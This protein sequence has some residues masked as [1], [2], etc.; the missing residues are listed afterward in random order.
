M[1]SIQMG[2]GLA[3][4]LFSLVGAAGTT[5]LRLFF[6]TTILWI[7]WRPWRFRFDK[8]TIKSLI[9]YGGSLG[10]MNLTFYF[11]LQRIPLGLAVTLEFVGPL[12]LSILTSRKKLDFLWV[13]LAAMGIYLVM[14]HSESGSALDIL[15]IIFALIAGGF[16]ALY[17]YFG[18]RAGH[19]LHG[20]IAA[21]AGMT[22]ATIVVLPFALTLDGPSMFNPAVLPLALLVAS[23]SSAL[24]Y[25]LE[26]IALKQLPTKTFGI[27]MSLEPA[28]ASL[29][30]LFLLKEQLLP[31]QWMAIG[32]II[33][34]SLGSVLKS[35]PTRP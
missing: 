3:K 28:I 13:L 23:L 27:L 26:M 17:I 9:F 25:S 7:I 16:W 4:S 30:G 24:P 1:I 11:S 2:A 12:T 34:A 14:P 6:A 20:G 31:I 18:Q 33:V 29:V 5:G 22:V 10:L 32:F 15:G 8:S 35:Q 21:T 19:A